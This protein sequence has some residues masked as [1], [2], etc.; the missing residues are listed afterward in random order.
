MNELERRRALLPEEQ[1]LRV[2]DLGCGT[3]VECF[4]AAR[5]VGPLGGGPGLPRRARAGGGVCGRPQ[6]GQTGLCEHE[7]GVEID[8]QHL[9]PGGQVVVVQQGGAVDGG[10]VGVEGDGHAGL[11]EL[12]QGVLLHVV[13]VSNPRFE[14]Q[15]TAVER[16]LADLNLRLYRESNNALIDSDLD[17]NG[18]RG[19]VPLRP[20]EGGGCR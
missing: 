4:I 1:T 5:L 7:R 12:G 16:T 19:V 11:I 20:G 18:L 13:D 3:G 10:V 9:V 14:D 2:L 8:L 6:Q 15:I 17:G